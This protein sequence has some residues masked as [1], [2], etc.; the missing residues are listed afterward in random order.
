[1]TPIEYEKMQVRLISDAKTLYDTS[2]EN[3]KKLING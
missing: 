2:L 3:M 1:M